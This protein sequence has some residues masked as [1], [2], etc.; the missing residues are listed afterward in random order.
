MLEATVK[1]LQKP[2][3]FAGL[4]NQRIEEEVEKEAW[5]KEEEKQKGKDTYEGE[6]EF[7]IREKILEELHKL[8]DE[9][10]EHRKHRIRYAVN[11]KKALAR[12]GKRFRRHSN[13]C[14]QNC[15]SHAKMCLE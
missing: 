7:T 5:R 4:S 3:N 12:N 11:N 2:I 8:M 6:Q 1:E 15:G 10:L 14:L 9:A 13:R